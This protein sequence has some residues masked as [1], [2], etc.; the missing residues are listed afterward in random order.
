VTPACSRAAREPTPVVRK[1][2]PRANAI[3]I[4][5]RPSVHYRYSSP[6]SS[7]VIEV[8]NSGFVRVTRDGLVMRRR[9]ET[10]LKNGTRSSVVTAT[11]SRYGRHRIRTLRCVSGVTREGRLSDEYMSGKRRSSVDYGYD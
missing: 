4:K 9:L 5:R 1:R 11:N 3:I 6:A 8:E 10:D 2:K 7:P